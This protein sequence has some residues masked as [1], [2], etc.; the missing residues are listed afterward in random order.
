MSFLKRQTTWLLSYEMGFMFGVFMILLSCESLLK[1]MDRTLFDLRGASTAVW[2][3]LED[4]QFRSGAPSVLLGHSGTTDFLC[5]ENHSE[6][7]LASIAYP[8]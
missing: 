5:A 1:R 7:K 6:L 2:D 4:V 3:M 8:L